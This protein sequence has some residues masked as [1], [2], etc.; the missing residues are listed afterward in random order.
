MAEPSPGR[1]P[2]EEYLEA[3]YDPDCEYVDG[4]LIQRTAAAEKYKWVKN[5]L[6]AYFRQFEDPCN[7]RVL[8][9]QRIHIPDLA[10]TQRCRIAD[11]SLVTR[12]HVPSRI[13]EKPPL[14][15]FEVLRPYETAGTLLGR[16]SD[17]LSAGVPY[18]WAIDVDEATWFSV[19]ARGLHRV[20]G[21]QA[22][23]PELSLTIALRP[24]FR[25]LE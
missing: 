10:A 11:V 23:I 12:P 15:A 9:N 25:E 17:L 6:L 18:L 5:R 4:R 7:I 3:T 8:E 1:V 16:L 13:L 14:A 21:Q 20:A 19:S 22:V 2:F 24:F